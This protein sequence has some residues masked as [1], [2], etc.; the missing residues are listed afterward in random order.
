MAL[1]LVAQCGLNRGEERLTVHPF[2][3]FSFLEITDNAD[4]PLP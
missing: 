4:K 2:I 1:I 3:Q